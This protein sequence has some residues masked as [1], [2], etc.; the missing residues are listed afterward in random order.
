MAVSREEP[1][2]TFFAVALLA[3][4]VGCSS[5]SSTDSDDAYR[6]GLSVANSDTAGA[7]K[8]FEEGL[9]ADPKHTRMRFALARLQYDTG[10]TQHLAERDALNVARALDEQHKTAD[11]QKATREA[12]DRHQKALPF[13]RA[14][15]ENL[16]IVADNDS[17]DA[18]KAWA[19]ELMMKCDV[20]FEEW[21]EAV[22][23]L[24]KAIKLGKP[25]GAKLAAMQDFLADLKKQGGKTGGHSSWADM[26]FEH[27]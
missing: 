24:D 21:S 27:H 18:R 20:F 3:V 2:R 8:I 17:D 22:T 11:A 5:A 6:R 25:Q 12:Q 7:I 10:E 19:Y 23:H 13:Y 9:A 4:S 15:R 14:A 16:A 26:P 1:L